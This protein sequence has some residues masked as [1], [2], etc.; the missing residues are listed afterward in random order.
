[1][2]GGEKGWEPG[3]WLGAPCSL[4]RPEPGSPAWGRVRGPSPERSRRQAPSRLLP[5]SGTPP[6]LTV[7]S[8]LLLQSR[9]WLI[10]VT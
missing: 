3:A 1:M 8:P 6:V 2:E 10:S 5:G 4:P 7:T 9:A